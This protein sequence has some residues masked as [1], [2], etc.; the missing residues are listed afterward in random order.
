MSLTPLDI[1]NKEFSV[2]LRG[3]DQQQVNDYLDEIIREFE[4]LLM[5]Q[6]EMEKKIQFNEEKIAHFHGIQETLNKSIIVA[7]D[8][9]D[10]LKQNAN[11]EAEMIIFEAER[12]ADKILK[13]AARQA[14]KINRE[15]DALQRDSRVFRQKVQLMIETQ[16]EMIKSEE[17]DKLLNNSQGPEVIA[18]T[19]KEVMDDRKRRVKEMSKEQ[20]REEVQMMRKSHGMNPA[21]EDLTQTKAFKPLSDEQIKRAHVHQTTTFETF[22]PEKKVLGEAVEDKK[23][24]SPSPKLGE[25]QKITPVKEQKHEKDNFEA[26]TPL[27]GKAVEEKAPE[28]KAATASAPVEMKEKTII[29]D[30]ATI[31]IGQKKDAPILAKEEEASQPKEEKNETPQVA[32]SVEE[33]ADDWKDSTQRIRVR[34]EGEALK[35]RLAERQGKAE[36]GKPL[37]GAKRPRVIHSNQEFT[38]ELPDDE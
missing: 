20:R 8:A 17:W 5:K 38:F 9:A 34:S 14:T 36:A 22:H 37:A 3:Y 27:K 30:D 4:N 31:Q 32:P 28:A 26:T 19:V 29:T 11:K 6:E 24:K 21:V 10:R 25:T 7:Q 18:P 12:V 35:Q 15:T 1:H 23:A 2:R 33:K 16:L 13:D